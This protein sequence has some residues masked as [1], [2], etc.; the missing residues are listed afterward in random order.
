MASASNQVSATEPADAPLVKISQSTQ[1]I[2]ALFSLSEPAAGILDPAMTPS[3]FVER[4]CE[5]ELHIDAIRFLAHAL[6]E[7]EA[8]WWACLAAREALENNDDAQ[9]AALE[10]A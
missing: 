8:V 6:P 5:A 2:C 1:E 7:R 9:Q 3:S 10:A 4:L